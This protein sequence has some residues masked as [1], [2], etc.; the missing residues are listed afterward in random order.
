M[1]SDVLTSLLLKAYGQGTEDLG[2]SDAELTLLFAVAVAAVIGIFLYAARDV[3]LRRGPQGEMAA[4]DKNNDYEKY[5]SGWGDDYVEFGKRSR[6]TETSKTVDDA[7]TDYYAVLGITRDATKEE[8]RARF[9]VL[10]KRLHPDRSR[11][12]SDTMARINRAYEVLSD[13]RSRREYDKLL[14]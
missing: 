8:I 12:D 2:P 7:S 10:A 11:G 9:R 14:D 5:H 1:I 13:A 4:S 3:I 6:G